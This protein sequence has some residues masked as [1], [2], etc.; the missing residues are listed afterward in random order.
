MAH[1]SGSCASIRNQNSLSWTEYVSMEE[2]FS[3]FLQNGKEIFEVDSS[4]KMINICTTV[5]HV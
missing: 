1:D 4:S 2:L 3:Y 5:V